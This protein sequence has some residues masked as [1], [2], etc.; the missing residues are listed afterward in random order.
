[1]N[2]ISAELLQKHY[3]FLQCILYV[4]FLLFSI[5]VKLKRELLIIGNE[6]MICIF[7]DCVDCERRLL[8]DQDREED[9]NN[10]RR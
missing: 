7:M 5:F 10:R 1:M 6:F 3:S 8:R 9:Y 4:F 2:L